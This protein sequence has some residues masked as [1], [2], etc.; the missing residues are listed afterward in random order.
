MKETN[1]PIKKWGE[2]L[3]K[4]FPGEDTQ[5]SNKHKKICSTSL[6][7]EEIQNQNHFIPK[8]MAIYK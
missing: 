4:H 2:D 3:N 8:R 5:M 6:V 1:N 7:T